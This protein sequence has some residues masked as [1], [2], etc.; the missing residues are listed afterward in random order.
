MIEIKCPNCKKTHRVPNDKIRSPVARVRCSRCK[1]VFVTRPNG[2]RVDASKPGDMNREKAK[3]T[4]PSVEEKQREQTAQAKGMSFRQAFQILSLDT[5][6]SLDQA[7]ESYVKVCAVY[8]RLLNDSHDKNKAAGRLYEINQAYEIALTYIKSRKPSERERVPEINKAHDVAPTYTAS[9]TPSEFE[10]TSKSHTDGFQILADEISKQGLFKATYTIFAKDLNTFLPIVIKSSLL[11]FAT[12]N[13]I[14]ILIGLMPELS[15]LIPGYWTH[16]W[17][18][19]V[20]SYA[21]FLLLMCIMLTPTSLFACEYIINKKVVTNGYFSLLFD[22][23]CLKLFKCYIFMGFVF[24]AGM[25]LLMIPFFVLFYLYS[26]SSV[27][28]LLALLGAIIVLLG[29][30]IFLGRRFLLFPYL[31]INQKEPIFSTFRNIERLPISNVLL[32]YMVSLPLVITDAICKSLQKYLD[33]IVFLVLID[34]FRSLNYAVMAC[35]A[36]LSISLL[37]A[38]KANN[39]E[40]LITSKV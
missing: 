13:F 39:R 32:V 22:H 1:C 40:M 25:I 27:I 9:R 23:R 2:N 11:L 37:Y 7:N 15:Q 33:F 12:S 31:A 19:V 5:D 36:M 14:R 3:S 4:A 26:E 30:G 20:S 18:I 16:S 24:V 17:T 8:L 21:L 35:I 34:F 38:R 28:I 6:T 29:T 10:G